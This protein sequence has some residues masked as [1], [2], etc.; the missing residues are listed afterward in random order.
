VAPSPYPRPHP[1]LGT[2]PTLG[3]AQARVSGAARG[4]A[5]LPHLLPSSV[6]GA[7]AA[8]RAALGGLSPAPQDYAYLCAAH[9]SRAR[10]P[11]SCGGRGGREP[12]LRSSGRGA[13]RRSPRWASARSCRRPSTRASR[14]CCTWVR[15]GGAGGRR[16]GAEEVQ[17]LCLC[18]CA[19]VCALLLLLLLL[20]LLDLYVLFSACLPVAC[21]QGAWPFQRT[22][23]AEAAVRNGAVA[24][25]R[26]RRCWA[27]RACPPSSFSAPRARIKG[28]RS[29]YEVPARRAPGSGREGFTRQG[30]RSTAALHLGGSSAAQ[31]EPLL[32][33]RQLGIHR[34]A[35]PRARERGQGRG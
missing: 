33:Q 21:A 9:G 32:A 7:Y 22:P 6:R 8:E 19:A 23:K 4:R 17:G 1:C 24:V 5:Q 12:T 13:A 34:C 28:R 18:T 35:R 16:L 26:P 10:R 11:P 30:R 15:R 29:A 3:T 27:A 2:P 25:G 20:L 31:R 14:G